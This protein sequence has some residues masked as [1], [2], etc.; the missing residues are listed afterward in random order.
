M[1]ASVALHF[2]AAGSEPGPKPR[3]GPV[4]KA[5]Q[6]NIMRRYAII[7]RPLPDGEGVGRKA[8]GLE[9]GQVCCVT[10]IMLQGRLLPA[11]SG[12][13]SHRPSRMTSR[14]MRRRPRMAPCGKGRIGRRPIGSNAWRPAAG[15]AL[16]WTR[17]LVSR[18]RPRWRRT[19]PRTAA[20]PVGRAVLGLAAPALLRKVGAPAGGGAVGLW[21][22]PWPPLF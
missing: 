5:R 3:A 9:A 12:G 8:R 18:S 17:V 11:R 16:T 15:D 22:E 19:S 1:V 13:R 21:A 2:P 20:K 10:P 4:P 7:C 6:G 14:R